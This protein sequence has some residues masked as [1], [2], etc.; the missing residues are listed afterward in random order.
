MRTGCRTGRNHG[1]NGLR[2]RSRWGRALAAA[3]TLALFGCTDGRQAES[4]G[5]P[6]GMPAPSAAAPESETPQATQGTGGAA[7]TPTLDL[8]ERE[9]IERAARDFVRSR[10]VLAEFSVEIDA[11]AD[12]YAR[13][14]VIPSGPVADPATVFLRREGGRWRGLVIGT[15]FAPEE[16]DSLRIPAGVRPGD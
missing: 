3:A 15:G 2:M 10:S 16:L 5:A 11:V 7:A 9:A 14:R 8:R 13:A 4:S 6:S 1:E 12:G